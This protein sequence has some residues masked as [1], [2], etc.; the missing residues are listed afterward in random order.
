MGKKVGSK[1]NITHGSVQPSQGDS[2][3]YIIM[4]MADTTWRLFVPTIGLLLVGHMLD[5]RLRTAPWLLL[6][7][8]ALGG[9]IALL[10]IRRQL[11]SGDGK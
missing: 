11:T 4:S 2:V 7:G 5:G 8:S 1:H 9:C 3:S 6:L 10:L